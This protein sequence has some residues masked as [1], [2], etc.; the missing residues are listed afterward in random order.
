MK[1]LKE[2]IMAIRS[3]LNLCLMVCCLISCGQYT[4]YQHLDQALIAQ[5]QG[6]EEAVLVHL[7]AAVDLQPHDAYLLRRLGW[8][9]HQRKEYDAAFVALQAALQ[10]EP[11]YLAVYQDLATISEAQDDIEG[12]IGWLEGAVAAVP[13]Y[14]GSYR[15]LANFYLRQ[16]RFQDA[17]SLLDGVVARWPDATW[18]HFGL[19]RLYVHLDLPSQAIESFRN[20]I[21]LDPITDVEYALF[22]EVHSALG[23]VYY[24]QGNYELATEFFKKAIDLNPAD[25]SSMNN[26][27]WVYATQQIQLEEGIRLSRLSLRL[28]P[29]APTYLDTLAELY[30]MS[31]DVG[32]AVKIIYQAIA[33]DPGQPELRAHLRRQLARF[34]AAGQGKV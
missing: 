16:E 5:A 7:Q 33:L 32:H 20:V 1:N 31:G 27:A 34:L 29:N 12:V 26:L 30:F 13:A 8:M 17:Q 9:Y 2:M 28:R 24:D 19:G 14:K 25:H 15:D 11:A 4:A 22:V 10:L 18:A 21:T 23:N 3:G 6:D